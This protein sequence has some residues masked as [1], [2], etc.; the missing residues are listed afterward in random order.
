[1]I[2]KTIGAVFVILVCIL[3][4]PLG[5]GILGGMFGIVM[6]VIGAVFGAI[7]GVIGA[8]FGGIFGIFGWLFDGL[9]DWH[10]PFHYFRCNIFTLA[11]V[12]LV[13]ALI[14]RNRTSRR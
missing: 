7:A 11:A 13:V 12:V 14:I 6:G 9:F 2:T 10:G 3:V 5:I 1:M 4:F 8:I